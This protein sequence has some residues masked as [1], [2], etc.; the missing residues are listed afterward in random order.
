MKKDIAAIVLA[1]GR[2]ERM[3]SDIPKVLHPVCGRAMVEYTRDLVGDI[4]A[5]K[6]V[7]VLGFKHEEVKKHLGKGSEFVIQRRLLG[8]ADAVK[9]ALARLKGF[10]GTVLILYADIPLLKKDTV[11]KLIAH[12][13]KND[14]AATILTAKSEKPAGYGRIIRDKYGSISDIREEKDADDLEKEIKEINTGIICFDKDKLLEGIREINPNP[15]KKEYYLTDIIGIFHRKGYLVESLRSADINEAMGVNS[16]IEL[17]K[18]NSLMQERINEKF[19]REGVSIIDPR[20]TF[21]GYGVKIG[22]DSVI[23][24]FTVIER[25]VKIGKRC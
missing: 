9:A 15:R 22:K 24:P 20:V 21:I 2:G 5:K 25:D 16:R 8:T 3:K 12:H 4:K 19:M 7:F 11:E 13:K 1:A 18:A 14:L 10:Y 23:Y 17:A 6:S